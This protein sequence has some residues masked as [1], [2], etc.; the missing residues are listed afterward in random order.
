[1]LADSGASGHFIDSVSLPC[2]L[3]RSF[4]VLR[5]PTAIKAAGLRTMHGTTTAVLKGFATDAGGAHRLF[6]LPA[7]TVPGL[8]RH[9]ISTVAC[10]CRAPL[11]SRVMYSNHLDKRLSQAS[12]LLSP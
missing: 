7:R 9:L 2:H 11:S 8:G 1:M 5:K 3:F 12:G 6:D 10:F 4:E